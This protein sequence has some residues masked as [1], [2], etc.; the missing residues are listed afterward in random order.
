MHKLFQDT[1]WEDAD[2]IAVIDEVEDPR[3]FEGVETNEERF[4]E[5]VGALALMA[6]CYDLDVPEEE[7][8]P[9]TNTPERREQVRAMGHELDNMGGFNLMLLAFRELQSVLSE[10][11]GEIA[12]GDMRIL[13]WAWDGVGI[14]AA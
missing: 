1:F 9:F 11:I 2:V 12:C 14:W 4:V 6:I 13:E 7:R 10:R 3:D 8:N 5:I